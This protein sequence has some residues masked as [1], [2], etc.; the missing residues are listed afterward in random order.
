MQIAE[1]HLFRIYFVFSLPF[2]LHL[3]YIWGPQGSQRALG[4]P[5]SKIYA[6]QMKNKYTINA[7]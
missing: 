1:T 7:K 4:D 6:K 3:F 5:K 2:I